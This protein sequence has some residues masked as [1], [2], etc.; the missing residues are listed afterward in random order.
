[1][2]LL[3]LEDPPT[4]IFAGNDNIALGVFNHIYELGLKIPDDISVIGFDDYK[5]V[6]YLHP[7]LTTIRQ[8]RYELKTA[9]KD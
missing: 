3:N 7:P 2:E 1:M 9:R 4:A 5:I 8:L 6:S